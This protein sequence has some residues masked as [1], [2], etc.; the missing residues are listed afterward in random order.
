MEQHRTQPGPEPKKDLVAFMIRKESKCSEC[1]DPLRPGNLL[2]M[3][4]EKPFCLDCADLGHLEFLPSGDVALTRRA[5]KYSRLRV[6]VVQWSRS[7]KRYERQGILVEPEAIDRAEA[8]SLADAD[9][10]ALRRDREAVRREAVDEE[11]VAAFAQGIR[12]QFPGCP[13]DLDQEIARH[14]CRKSSG[15]VGR[16]AAAKALDPKPILLAVAAHI[17]HTRTNYDELL[18]GMIDRQSAREAVRAQVQE[19]LRQWSRAS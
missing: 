13:P 15:R 8:E 3:E 16:T 1:G 19:I 5:T 9:A 2:T 6:V 14:A 11:Y 12:E 4:A 17:R 18:S 7:R 10:R